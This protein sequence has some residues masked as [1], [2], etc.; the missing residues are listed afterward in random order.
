MTNEC[1]IQ[2]ASHSLGFGGVGASGQGRYGGYKG[3]QNFS[4]AKSIVLKG[5]APPGLMRQ[6]E[7]PYTDAKVNRL[8]K[9]AV[10]LSVKDMTYVYWWAKLLGLVL[11]LMFIKLFFF[12]K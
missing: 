8:R 11:F 1:L 9:W 3:F 6:L 5:P 4:N 7:P 10:W 12:S 2:I